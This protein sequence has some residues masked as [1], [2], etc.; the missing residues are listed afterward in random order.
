MVNIR[1]TAAACSHPELSARTKRSRQ[2]LKSF[3]TAI[4]CAGS[5]MMLSTWANAVAY[6]RGATAPWGETTNKPGGI[7]CLKTRQNGSGGCY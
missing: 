1:E 7:D 4:L 6:I 2:S 3:A 5:L